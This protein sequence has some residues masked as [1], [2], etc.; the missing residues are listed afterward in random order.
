MSS[1]L[2]TDKHILPQKRISSFIFI[3]VVL[4]LQDWEKKKKKHNKEIS[5]KNQIFLFAYLCSSNFRV[6][7][8]Q[9]A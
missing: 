8:M 2:E 6:Q 5:L 4:H 7:F 3:Y 9:Q 1:N